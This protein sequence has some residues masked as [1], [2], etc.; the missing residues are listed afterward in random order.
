MGGAS[1]SGM[2]ATAF[3]EARAKGKR[4]NARFWEANPGSAW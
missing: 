1:S 2:R 4:Y 3:G